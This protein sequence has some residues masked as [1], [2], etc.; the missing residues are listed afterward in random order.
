[1][2]QQEADR[3]GFSYEG[4][5]SRITLSVHSFL[6]AVGLTAHVFTLLADAAIRPNMVAG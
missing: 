1:M 6:Q 4:I 5:W 2:T 3:Q